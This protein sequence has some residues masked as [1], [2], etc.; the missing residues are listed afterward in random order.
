LPL[1]QALDIAA[2]IADALG[3]AHRAGIVHRDLKPA[4][5]M[6][7]K[8][9]SGRTGLLDVKLLDFGLARS[10]AP[11]ADAT[12]RD[13]ISGTGLVVGTVPYM[14]PEQVTG[15]AVDVRTD[16]FAFGALVYEMLSGRR[17][18][19][20]DSQAGVIAAILDREPAPI[21]DLQPLAPP[22]LDRL[23]RKCLAKEPDSRW[24]TAA[25][26]ADELRWIAEGQRKVGFHPPAARDSRR[27]WTLG[28]V[29]LLLAAGL[30]AVGWYARRGVT[31][32]PVHVSVSLADLGLRLG[33]EGIAI[34]P[35]G[36]TL[37]FVARHDDEQP[38]LY[39]R[40]LSEPHARAVSGTEGA[41]APFFSP[42]GKWIAFAAEG[43]LVKVLVDGD[44][45]KVI[46]PI[47]YQGLSRGHWTADG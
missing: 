33:S 43:R 25:D 3:A 29:V 16:L 23:I 26:L 2:Q 18:F 19:D 7:V 47:D 45:K 32:D 21:T 46:C 40:P 27:R 24:Q 4:N 44:E 9:G 13:S 41:S 17:A 34:S 12:G 6:L 15:R 30:M 5:I 8:A 31:A 22:S 28:S 20:A 36:K 11:S 42:D 39:L 10:M 38:R 14:A 37:A 35:D 1:P